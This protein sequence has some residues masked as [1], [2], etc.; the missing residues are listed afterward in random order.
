MGLIKRVGG[1]I[2]VVPFCGQFAVDNILTD[3][4]TVNDVMS[5]GAAFDTPSTSNV[6]TCV[7]AAETHE[8]LVRRWRSYSVKSRYS[9][10][11]VF[12]LGVLGEFPVNTLDNGAMHGANVT[13]TN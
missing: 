11:R 4:V 13:H 3:A 2:G 9:D 10:I 8:R 6:G 5:V 12:A 1:K 7:D